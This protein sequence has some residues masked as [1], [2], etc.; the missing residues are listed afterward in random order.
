MD[1]KPTLSKGSQSADR[2]AAATAEEE[3][4]RFLKPQALTLFM[5]AV[6]RAA[7]AAILGTAPYEKVD[8]INIFFFSST[9]RSS[10]FYL[11]RFCDGGGDS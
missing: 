6:N 10:F 2:A 9:I 3:R 8:V 7:A 5:A 11:F 1:V 4:T